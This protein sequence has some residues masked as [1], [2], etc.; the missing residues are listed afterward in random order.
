M[1]RRTLSATLV[2]ALLC[3]SPAASAGA[4]EVGE[5]SG[6]Q[7]LPAEDLATLKKVLTSEVGKIDVPKG[8]SLVVSASVVKLETTQDK[9]TSTTTCAVSLAV[10]D[11]KTGALRGLTSGTSVVTT[12][13]GDKSAR[14]QGIEGAVQGATRGLPKFVK[15]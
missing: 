9:N 3:L 13:P 2:A 10:R 8:T 6:T 15:P 7:A 1:V 14:S 11:G 12:K 4:I 5:V